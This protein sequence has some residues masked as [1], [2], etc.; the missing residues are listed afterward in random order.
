MLE[1]P[2][3]ILTASNRDALLVEL[4]FDEKEL[5]KWS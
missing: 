2:R 3:F 1:H 5:R 4:P